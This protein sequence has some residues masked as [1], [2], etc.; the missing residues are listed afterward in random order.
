MQPYNLV[1]ER[2]VK[3]CIESKAGFDTAIIRLYCCSTL[4]EIRPIHIE[5]GTVLSPKAF[6]FARLLLKF[7]YQAVIVHWLPLEMSVVTNSGF[8]AIKK[9]I[10]GSA[11]QSDPFGP[12]FFAYTA[13]HCPR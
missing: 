12:D 13:R 11:D 3:E 10:F 4:R 5:N 6:R 8:L 7:F 2:I 9:E 1:S